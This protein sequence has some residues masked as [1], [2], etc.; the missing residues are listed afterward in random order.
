M[1]TEEVKILKPL[2]AI[3]AKCIDCSG[4]NMAEVRRCDIRYCSLWTYRMGKNPRLKG[5]GN[6]ANL[7]K[8]I[9]TLKS[10]TAVG[11]S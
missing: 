8:S 7:Q 3:R 1:T 6:L 5:K 9:S 10:A 2:K 11:Q 4:G